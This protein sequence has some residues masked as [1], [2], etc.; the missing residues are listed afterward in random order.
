MHISRVQLVNYRNFERA[1]AV[2]NKGVNTVIGENSSGK[3]NLFRAIR[4]LLDD[5]QLRWA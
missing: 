3:S 1:D 2:F 4:M 5:D